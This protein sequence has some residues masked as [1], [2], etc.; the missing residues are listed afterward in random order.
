MSWLMQFAIILAA[1]ALFTLAFTAVM[2][3]LNQPPHTPAP[4][5]DSGQS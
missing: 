2:Y 1:V 4:V 5:S 3:Y